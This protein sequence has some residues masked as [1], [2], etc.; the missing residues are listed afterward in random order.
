MLGVYQRAW[1]NHG[2]YAE[3]AAEAAR[4]P[5]AAAQHKGVEVDA[6]PPVRVAFSSGGLLDNWHGIVHDPSGAVLDANLP[7]G[8]WETVDPAA[9]EA[10][11][12]FGGTLVRARHLWGDWYYCQFT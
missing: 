11:A 10:R 7:P 1:R 3:I 9:R 5:A 2:E 6:G 4:D 8:V 12:F